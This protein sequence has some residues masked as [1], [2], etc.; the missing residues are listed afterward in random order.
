[1]VQ[2]AHAAPLYVMMIM[3]KTKGM[4]KTQS[5]RGNVLWF[6]MIGVALLAAITMVLSRS[7]SSVDQA[8]NY[9]QN[10]VKASQILRY[11]RGLEAGIERL[12][13]VNGCS[14]NDISFE[15]N[16]SSGYTNSN[17]PTDNSCHLFE[18]EGAGLS[19]QNL[20]DGI[21][22]SQWESGNA[23]YKIPFFTGMFEVRNVGQDCSAAACSDLTFIVSDLKLSMCEHINDLL[24]INAPSGDGMTNYDP[25]N[26]APSLFQ[27]TFTFINSGSVLGEI[28]TGLEGERAGCFLNM[29][30]NPTFYYVLLAR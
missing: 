6:I 16:I 1:M 9:E 28:M 27:G 12:K 3:T 21:F 23:H 4:N 2:A 17:S 26:Y 5:Q 18:I 14:E 15:N 24:S 22:D 20:P 25:Y 19:W 13:Q 11:V 7:G 29:G 30:T 10:S 8:G